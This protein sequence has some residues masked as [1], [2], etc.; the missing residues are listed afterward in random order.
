MTSPRTPQTPPTITCGPIRRELMHRRQSADEDEI[1]D[2][3]MAAER[4]RGREDHVIAD[5]AVVTDMAAIHEIAAIAD[6]RDAAAG[7][8]TGVHGRRIRGW[9]S[10]A[11]ISSLVSSPR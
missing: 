7:Y 5:L 10:P 11:P 8:G 4:G 3:A 2:L 9:C 6:P 1:A